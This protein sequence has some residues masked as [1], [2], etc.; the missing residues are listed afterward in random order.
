MHSTSL[1]R[2][3]PDARVIN[4]ETSITRSDDYW[5]GKGINYRMH[6]DHIA[7]LPARSKPQLLPLPLSLFTL[8]PLFPEQCLDHP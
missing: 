4:L 3:A 5:K 8:K 6:P 1:E 2:A 7:C